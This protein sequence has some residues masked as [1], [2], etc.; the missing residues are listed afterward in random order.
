MSGR[1]WHDT[2]MATTARPGDAAIDAAVEL[3]RAAG[4]RFVFLHGSRAGGGERADSDID[5]AALFDHELDEADL[6]S[7]LPAGVDLLVLDRAPL[8]LAG[9]VALHGRLL[10]QDDPARRVE[11]QAMTRKIYL[12]ER[13]RVEQARADFAEAQRGG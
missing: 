1:A 2:G 8:E 4:A 10:A 6:R 11:W 13:F 5:V 12:D 3:L 9:R 7:R